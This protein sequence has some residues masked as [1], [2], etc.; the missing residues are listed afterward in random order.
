MRRSGVGLALAA[1][2]L[3]AACGGGEEPTASPTTPTTATATSEPPTS[4]PSP[5]PTVP[6]DTSWG[7][8]VADVDSAAAI[9]AG[10]SVEERAGRVIMARIPGTTAVGASSE[11]VDLSLGGA[12]LFDDNIDSL[13]QVRDLNAGL[14]AAAAAAGSP[15]PLLIG[16]DQEGGVVARVSA[17]ATE[18]PTYMTLGAARDPAVA[19]RAAST[20]G[21]E[22][23]ALGFTV[24]FAPVADVTIGLADPTIGSRSA[25]DD[26][27]LVGK[28][29]NGSVEGYVDAGLVPVIKHFPGHGSVPADSHETLPVQPASLDELESRDLVPFRTAIAAG[30]PSV[31]VAH[32]DVRALD[33][34]VP[35]SLSPRVVG[36]LRDDLGF[37]GLVFTD[38]EEMAAVAG[39]YGVGESAVR[40]LAA[41]VDVVLMPL[42]AATARAAIVDA[43]AAD[44]LPATRLDEA[45]TRVVATGLWQART[46]PSQPALD[47]VGS[48]DHHQVS[49][50]TSLAG[51]TVVSGPCTGRLVGDAI[52][53]VGGTATDQARLAE[54]A[55]A[56]GLP[57]GS[58]SIVRLLG[59]TTGDA[60]DVVV[61]LDRPYGLAASQA[62]AAR[63]ALY[64]RTPDAFRALVDVLLGTAS[65]RGALP[66]QVEGLAPT[67]CP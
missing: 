44:T 50:D 45:A 49:Y 59:S 62:G 43:V 19:T 7:P 63:L 6:P 15:A 8:S 37:E 56:A 11:I 26:P 27:A 1:V 58:G 31:M 36:L 17:G 9:V 64:G 38:A 4:T 23:R 51:L 32:I 13:Q 57:V 60:G 24:V 30:A 53:V 40:A 21:E 52:Q 39:T 41:G 66:V 48:P 65:G 33:P 28:I 67:A 42:D 10:M 18:F 2:V 14:Q 55:E 16:V 46:S 29:V 3:T 5:T 35:A 61:S 22:L 47:T 34:G 12:I 25:G 54:A 20:S